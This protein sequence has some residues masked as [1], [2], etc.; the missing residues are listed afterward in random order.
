[1]RFMRAV[2]KILRTD[3]IRYHKVS[4]RNSKE[5]VCCSVNYCKSTPSKQHVYTRAYKSAGY[6]MDFDGTFHASNSFVR[7][8]AWAVAEQNEPD[9]TDQLMP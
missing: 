3:Q 1:V 8:M 2:A 5:G 4:Q 7:N 6:D 9:K